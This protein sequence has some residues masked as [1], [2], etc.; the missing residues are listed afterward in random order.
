MRKK[1]YE[2]EFIRLWS[3][4]KEEKNIK[5]DEV[6]YRGFRFSLIGF[7]KVWDGEMIF[8]F[9][10][11]DKYKRVLYFTLDK[12]KAQD[13]ILALEE[14]CEKIGYKLED[15]SPYIPRMMDAL[16]GIN[17]NELKKDI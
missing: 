4:G 12:V 5:G 16:E 11:L 15:V 10:V 9:K 3:E 8:Y 6:I 2:D 1:L 7:T 14:I 17:K 13:I